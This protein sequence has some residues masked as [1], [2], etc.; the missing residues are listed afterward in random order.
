MRIT[1]TATTV[2]VY[3]A[4]SNGTATLSPT[5]GPYCWGCGY[6]QSNCY[7]YVAYSITHRG[8]EDEVLPEPWLSLNSSTYGTGPRARVLAVSAVDHARPQVRAPPKVLTFCHFWG[9]R[10]PWYPC[11]LR[12]P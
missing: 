9:R 6:T 5:G 11:D 1:V 7:C 4:T 8:D 10:A 2:R 3:G 12:G